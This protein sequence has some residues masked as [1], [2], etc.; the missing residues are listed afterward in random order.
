MEQHIT[1]NYALYWGDCCE[2]LRSLPSA[3]VHLSIYSPP[4]CGLYHY[5]SSERDLSNSRNRGEFLDHYA[6]VVHELARLTLPGRLTAV[7]AAD[8]PMGNGVLF[9]F[10]GEIIRLHES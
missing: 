1:D 10:P 2:I 8:I 9:D 3:S 7:H 4:F 6:F 5:S